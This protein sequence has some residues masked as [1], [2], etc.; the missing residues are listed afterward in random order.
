MKMFKKFFSGLFRKLVHRTLS[1]KFCYSE[2][3]R[4]NRAFNDLSIFFMKNSDKYEVLKSRIYDCSPACSKYFEWCVHF[5]LLELDLSNCNL[6]DFMTQL[7]T[8]VD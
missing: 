4:A 3:N 5:K 2:R 6:N 8:I 1:L 7:K